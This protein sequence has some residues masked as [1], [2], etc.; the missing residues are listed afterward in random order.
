MNEIK[1]REEFRRW[2]KIRMIDLDTNQAKLAEQLG[3]VAP[4]ISDAMRGHPN[5]RK[6][7]VPMIRALGGNP[8]LFRAV[9][10]ENCVKKGA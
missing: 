10:D 9:I 3:T 7:L 8:E 1:S 5:G 2:A 6:S 4:R